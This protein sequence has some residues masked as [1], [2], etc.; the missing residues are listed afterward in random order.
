M[1]K[2]ESIMLK[3]PIRKKILTINF[4]ENE[5][6]YMCIKQVMIEN[7]LKKVCVE[8]CNG[9]LKS[10]TINYFSRNFFKKI[11][12]VEKEIIK[13]SGEIKLKQELFGN[14]KICTNERRPLQGTLVKGIAGKDFCLKLSFFE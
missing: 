7:N 2:L 5:D 9:K 14:I 13:V 12:F 1:L 11:D 10:G 4:E 3:E 8:N 6:I